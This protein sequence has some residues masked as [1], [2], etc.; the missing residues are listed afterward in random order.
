MRYYPPPEDRFWANVC[1]QDDGCWRWRAAL[2]SQ[3]YGNGFVVNGR[4]VKPHRFAWE[5]LRGPIPE[6]LVIDHLCRNR[7]CVNP[8]HLEPVT[9]GE[10]TRRGG[11]SIKTHCPQGHPYSDDNTMVDRMGYRHCRECSRRRNREYHKTRRRIRTPKTKS[12]T[13]KAETK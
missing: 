4:Q 13:Q 1:K 10:N 8:D 6:G 5:L 3:G 7:A 11:E 2:T 9:V 12:Q